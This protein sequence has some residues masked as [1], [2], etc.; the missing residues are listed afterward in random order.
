ML[1]TRENNDEN[2]MTRKINLILHSEVYVN[3]Y[4]LLGTS[5]PTERVKGNEKPD[6]KSPKISDQDHGHFEIKVHNSAFFSKKNSRKFKDY[7]PIVPCY[8]YSYSIRF[9]KVLDLG[10]ALLQRVQK[11][12]VFEPKM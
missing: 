10:F 1:R 11:I 6:Y 3:I 4:K 12:S 8:N 2:K 7:G 9:L 5:S